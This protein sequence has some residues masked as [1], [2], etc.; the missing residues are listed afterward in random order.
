MSSVYISKKM[1]HLLNYFL[2]LFFVA[3][4]AGSAFAASEKENKILV[5]GVDGMISTAIDYASTP[6]V[7]KLIGNATY[8]LSGYGGLPAYASTGWATMLTGVSAEKHGATNENS[9]SGNH[10][11]AYPSV[12]SR[13]KSLSSGTIIASV[14]RDAEINTQLNAA[15]DFKAACASDEEALSKSLEFVKQP[16]VDVTFVQ[17]SGPREAGETVGY[18]LRQAQYVLAVQQI[19]NL[20]AELQTAIQSRETY[21]NE[22][23]AIFFVSTHGGTESGMKTN[24]TPEETDVPMIFSGDGIDNKVLNAEKLDPAAGGDNILKINRGASKTYVR[25]PIAGTPL[26]GMDTYTL[27]MWIKPGPN[28]S[29]P[30]I[31]GDKDWGSGA[32]P[33]F[34]ICRRG[35]SWRYNFANDKRQRY[36]TDA[37]VAIE[38]G[39]WHHLAVSF[40]KTQGCRLYQD[41]ELVNEAAIFYQA[42]DDMASPYNYICLAQEG[43]ESYPDGGP[44]WAGSFN[45]VRIWTS[46]VS[47]ENLRKYM[48]LRHIE[49]SDHP[50]LASLE[51][52][53]KMD[54]VKGNIIKDYSGKGHDGELMGSAMERHPFYPIRLTDVTVNMLGHLGIA[55]DG[56]WGLEGNALKANV[57][58]RLFKVN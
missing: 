51:L 36:D 55:V 24:N 4:T 40:K 38:D 45:E 54:E 18:Q 49:Q 37:E 2:S 26:Q 11:D 3:V 35:A 56:G 28:G 23:W 44:N 16:D 30:S 1:K 43:T 25:I 22:D 41:G 33:G 20:V 12:V 57:P 58:Y 10:F 42:A 50:D 48:H 46:V 21:H 34:V 39:N 8:H 52:Y 14:V 53:L 17:F 9:F 7:D 6:S 29:D 31:V 13:I 19:D 32:N 47:Q 15:A 27:E 5:I